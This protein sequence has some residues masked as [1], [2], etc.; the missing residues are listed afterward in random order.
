M[1][2]NSSKPL[3]L[4]K[5][6]INKWLG[7]AGISLASLFAIPNK[8]DAQVI[9]PNGTRIQF[10]Y[11]NTWLT[12]SNI[13][14]NGISA[15][16]IP[17]NISATTYIKPWLYL[18]DQDPQNQIGALV[19]GDIF[20]TWKNVLDLVNYNWYFLS[21]CSDTSSYVRI[22]IQPTNGKKIR[23]KNINIA[24][25]FTPFGND[26]ARVAIAN[27]TFPNRNNYYFYYNYPINSVGSRSISPLTS[28]N[29]N[30]LAY[31]NRLEIR[32]MPQG[33][34]T[35]TPSE[36]PDGR[37]HRN[38]DKLAIELEYE[39]VIDC[40]PI[41][42]NPTNQS[43]YKWKENTAQYFDILPWAS[44]VEIKWTDNPKTTFTPWCPN[45]SN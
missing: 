9:I 33:C 44:V 38:I 43:T 5:K 27:P 36:T 8:S 35:W 15:D 25:W 4:A 22:F 11:N 2:L 17:S 13:L 21:K 6:T 16:T 23:I 42:I 19:N 26:L 40:W 3:N 31:H 32:I 39:P 29:W 37:P 1:K 30:Y 12:Q 20:W 7:I 14:S 10:G 41:T 28:G 34:M 18:E 45:S 24:D